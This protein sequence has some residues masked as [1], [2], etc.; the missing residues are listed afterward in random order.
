MGARSK[1]KFWLVEEWNDELN[2][3]LI[4]I[5]KRWKKLVFLETAFMVLKHGDIVKLISGVNDSGKT[6]SAIPQP[7]Y[8]NWLLRNFWIKYLK[9]HPITIEDSTI[10][11]KIRKFISNPHLEEQEKHNLEERLANLLSN[12]TPKLLKD[13]ERKATERQKVIKSLEI[14]KPYTLKRNL[15]FYPS[16]E[17]VREKIADGT[18]FNCIGVNE[19]MKAAINL[20][21]WNPETIDMILELFTE[22]SSNNYIIFEYQQ[23]RRP[24][25]LLLARFNVWQNKMSQEWM[26]TSIPSSIYRTEDPLYTA[27]IEKIKG[28]RKISHWFVHKSGNVNFIAKM[29]APKISEKTAQEFEELRKLAK[30]EY[31]GNL[32]AKK[33]LDM[34]WYTKIKEIYQQVQDGE[35]AFFDLPNILKDKYGLTNDQATKF[36]REYDKFDRNFKLLNPSAEIQQTE[37]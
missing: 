3:F 30:E 13:I 36:M 16:P 17:R 5:K 20:R 21:S 9:S 26:V 10:I 18:H 1:K 31:E 37:L 27:E 32:K 24:P 12:P 6:W 8:A 11:K 14:L 22:R 19:G 33:Q 25:K 35:I 29:R 15:I 2:A 34:V 28:D 23:S 4:S 7:R